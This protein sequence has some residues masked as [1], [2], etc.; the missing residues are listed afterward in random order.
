MYFY[1]CVYVYVYMCMY[2][3][4]YTYVHIYRYPVISD[5]GL[6][7]WKDLGLKDVRNGVCVYGPE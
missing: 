4:A 7:F 6:G 2:I 1:M 5:G 3:R